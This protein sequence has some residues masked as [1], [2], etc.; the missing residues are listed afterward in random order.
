MRHEIRRLPVPAETRG[1]RKMQR[2]GRASR[3]PHVSLDPRTRRRRAM[4]S[5]WQAAGVD[6]EALSG[7]EEIVGEWADVKIRVIEA[8]RPTDIH[9]QDVDVGTFGRSQAK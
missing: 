3:D 9:L 8:A 1:A 5:K 2:S 4:R 7:R 6:M